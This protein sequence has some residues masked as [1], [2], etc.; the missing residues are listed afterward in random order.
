MDNS[1]WTN[2]AV[3]FTRALVNMIEQSKA[4]VGGA[5]MLAPDVFGTKSSVPRRHVDRLDVVPTTRDQ[6]AHG[7]S[8]T[9]AASTSFATS[10][11]STR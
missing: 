8:G 11:S 9:S 3:P 2:Q 1:G 5:M 10:A 6:A 7:P 4:I